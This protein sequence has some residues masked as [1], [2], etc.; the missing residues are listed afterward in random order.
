MT[1][2]VNDRDVVLSIASVSK[3]FGGVQALTD[4]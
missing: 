3:H 2:E 1:A 4:V